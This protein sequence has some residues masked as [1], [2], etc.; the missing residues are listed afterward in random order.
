MNSIYSLSLC[1]FVKNEEHCIGN[2]I[3]SVINYVNEV[4]LIDTGSTDN[5]IEVAREACIRNGPNGTIQ[6]VPLRVY[7][8]G[9][10]NFG[11]IRT[12]ASHLASQEW[13][14]MLDAD[15]ELFNAHKLLS[16]MTEGYEACAFP[17]RRWLDIEKKQQTEL[18]AF[19]DWQVRFYKNN[20]DFTWK[21]ELH[22]YFDGAPVTH[23]QGGIPPD[24]IHTPV[25]EHFHDVYKDAERLKEREKLYTRLAE[26]A[27][28]T[29]EGGHEI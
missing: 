26:V 1:T 3:K 17:R 25:I 15:E 14:L 7:R 13:V 28:V 22:E 21:R 27:G 10:T 18:N 5:T 4:I 9:F 12:L 24:A 11:E 8:V 29:V 23:I 2:M 16:L 19:P 6:K 20:K